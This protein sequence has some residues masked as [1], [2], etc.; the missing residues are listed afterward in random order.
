GTWLTGLIFLNLEPYKQD[1]EIKFHSWQ[2]IFFG[3]AWV[4]VWIVLWII[5]MVFFSIGLWSILWGIRIVFWL[6]FLAIW[7]LLMVKGFSCG[8]RFKLP[9]SGDLA[10][11]QA[12]K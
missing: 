12:A 10:E 9:I 7:I 1:P 8:R 3:I 5:T 6:G 11:Q 2:A 4:A